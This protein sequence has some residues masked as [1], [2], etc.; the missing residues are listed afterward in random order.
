MTPVTHWARAAALALTAAWLVMAG[1]CKSEPEVE[2][3]TLLAPADLT[4][5]E[6]AI[7]LYAHLEQVLR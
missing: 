3:P 1:G 5:D 2:L 7:Y 4:A 6:E